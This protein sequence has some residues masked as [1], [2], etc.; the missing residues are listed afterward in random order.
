MGGSDPNME[1]MFFNPLLKTPFFIFLLVPCKVGPRKGSWK[2]KEPNESN[3]SFCFFDWG[4]WQWWKWSTNCQISEIRFL[5]LYLCNRMILKTSFRNTNFIIDCKYFRYK[6]K[7]SF[8]TIM[9]VGG[10]L[11]VA[12]YICHSFHFFLSKSFLKLWVF[13]LIEWGVLFHLI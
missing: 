13:M 5:D 11:F 10:G 1:N 2:A 12:T 6:Q 3:G 4:P 9:E 7:S 8:V